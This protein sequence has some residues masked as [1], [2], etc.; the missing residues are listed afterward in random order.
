MKTRDRD[1]VLAEYN[2]DKWFRIYEKVCDYGP[3]ES[4]AFMLFDLLFGRSLMNDKGIKEVIFDVQAKTAMPP[5]FAF[6]GNQLWLVYEIYKIASDLGCRSFCELGS[7]YGR[8]IAW[9]RALAQSDSH[10]ALDFTGMEFT[11]TGRRCLEKLVEISGVSGLK[12]GHV[13]F[14][15]LS[16]LTSSN[17][18]AIVFTVHAIEQIPVLPDDF[19][20]VLRE[21]FPNACFVHFEPVGWQ[22]DELNKSV[23]SSE[24]YAVQHDYNRNFMALLYD[25]EHRGKI[26]VLETARDEVC[27]NTNN[28]TSK[29]VWRP[30]R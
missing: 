3:R 1:A 21:K 23:G 20:L 9:L 7:G 18:A 6:G 29:V 13:D 15:N 19:V 17:K 28:G 16:S 14:Y 8:N 12:S 2:D 27:I 26:E 25:A 22:I 10:E 11:E 24:S 30:L 5:G 4:L